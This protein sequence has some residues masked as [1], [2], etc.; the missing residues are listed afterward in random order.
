MSPHVERHEGHFPIFIMNKGNQYVVDLQA[1]NESQ[2]EDT[3]YEV[4][5]EEA[6]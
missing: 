1:L 6:K 5:E 3:Y 4:D 2:Y